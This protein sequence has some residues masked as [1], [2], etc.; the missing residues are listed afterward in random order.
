M[1]HRVNSWN[2]NYC[3]IYFYCNYHCTSV[4]ND[5][6]KTEKWIC[7]WMPLT[8]LGHALRDLGKESGSYLLITMMFWQWTHV[9]TWADGSYPW[10]DGASPDNYL[11]T[12][13]ASLVSYSIVWGIG[14]NWNFEW[15]DYGLFSRRSKE[16]TSK[17]G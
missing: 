8:L 15:Q 4:K 13:P 14:N 10:T 7:Q 12:V 9:C 17:E 6:N 5:A 11:A 2:I 16:G 1:K 3:I